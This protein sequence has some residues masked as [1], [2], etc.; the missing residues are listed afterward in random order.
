MLSKKS[1]SF[2]ICL[3]KNF[4]K[5]VSVVGGEENNTASNTI[6]IPKNV[7]VLDMLI[8]YSIVNIYIHICIYY[9]YTR[10]CLHFTTVGI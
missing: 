9:V 7:D 2:L 10:M 4:L 3:V 8:G 6:Q 1:L 5:S